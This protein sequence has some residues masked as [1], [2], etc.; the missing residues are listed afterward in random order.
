MGAADGETIDSCKNEPQVKWTMV[1]KEIVS[2]LVS[3]L[4][5]VCG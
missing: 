4:K 2:S 5:M 3:K 1:L